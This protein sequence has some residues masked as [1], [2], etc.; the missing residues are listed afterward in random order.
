MRNPVDI[1]AAASV[2][3]VEFGYG[4]GMEA[5][6][7]DPNIDAVVPVLMLTKDTGIPPFD[8]IIKLARKFPGKPILVTFSAERQY[9]EE[10]KEF[11][12]PLGVPTS[13][14]SSN[15]SKSFLFYIAAI[16]Q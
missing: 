10:C 2:K 14:K 12:E 15:L 11:L 13:P 7:K 1:W 5:V 6:L 9:M 8:F 3:G 16:G 4:E